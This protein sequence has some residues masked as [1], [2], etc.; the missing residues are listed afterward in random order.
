MPDEQPVT[1]TEMLALLS[2]FEQ[3]FKHKLKQ[4][5]SQ[6]LRHDLH[7][8]RQENFETIDAVELSGRQH[9]ERIETRLLTAFHNRAAPVSLRLRRLENSDAG[10]L[11]RPRIC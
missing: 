9:T 2:G 1:R 8:V 7:E 3:E 10:V 11:M 6:D 5:L 4:D